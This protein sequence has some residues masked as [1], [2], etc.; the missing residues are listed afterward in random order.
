MSGTT[1]ETV[2]DANERV[3]MKMEGLGERHFAVDVIAGA[4]DLC[5]ELDGNFP[6]LANGG[7]FELLRACE[8]SARDLEAIPIPDGGWCTSVMYR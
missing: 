8:C 6:R 3:T 1:D 4:Q 5:D 7:G 2:P